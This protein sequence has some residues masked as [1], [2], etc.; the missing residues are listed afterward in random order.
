[1]IQEPREIRYPTRELA[2][3][4]VYGGTLPAM[5]ANL[6]DIST[7]GACIEWSQSGHTELS[8]GSLIRMTVTLSALNKSHSVSAKVVWQSGLKVGV[9][10]LKESELLSAMMQTG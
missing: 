2:H 5:W 4:E 6:R 1:M 3:I 9:K 10:F 7:S 8:E